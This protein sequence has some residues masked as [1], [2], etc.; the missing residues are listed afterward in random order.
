MN[1]IGFFNNVFNQFGNLVSFVSSPINSQLPDTFQL[2][3]IG[4]FSIMEMFSVALLATL[5]FFLVT[6][7]VRLIIGG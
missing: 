5:S 2:E 3:L 4:N 1:V 6:H 7:L